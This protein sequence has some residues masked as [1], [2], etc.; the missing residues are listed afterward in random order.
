MESSLQVQDYNIIITMKTKAVLYHF[1]FPALIAGIGMLSISCSNDDGNSEIPEAPNDSI[2]PSEPEEKPF[3]GVTYFEDSVK[4]QFQ[5]LNSDS[6]AVDT[7]KEGEDIIF[8]LTITNTGSDWVQTIPMENFSDDI[9][10]VYSSDEV[11]MGKPWD[12]R[13]MSY[14]YPLLSPKTVREYVCSWL[15]V[16][17]EDMVNMCLWIENPNENI[18]NL[19]LD[20]FFSMTKGNRPV[21]YL[22]KDCRHPLPKGNYYT[23]FNVSIIEGRR[24]TIRMEFNIE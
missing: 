4:I 7:F 13:L 5:L 11:N 6:V 24:T 1:L 12:E 16:P 10:S 8:K 21:V 14:V 18:E 9:F 3:V 15:E 22:K 19:N 23:Q 20:R 2:V 17:D